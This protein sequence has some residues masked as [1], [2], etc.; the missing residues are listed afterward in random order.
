VWGTFADAV[1]VDVVMDGIPTQVSGQIEEFVDSQSY[2][3][4]FDHVDPGLVVAAS[5]P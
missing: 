2:S 1:V 5:Y 4:A 3:F